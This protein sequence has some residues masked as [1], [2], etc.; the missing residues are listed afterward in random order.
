MLDL[1]KTCL[2]AQPARLLT[3]SLLLISIYSLSFVVLANLIS[4]PVS[5]LSC[6]ASRIITSSRMLVDR[7]VLHAFLW[8]RDPKKKV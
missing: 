1:R 5:P 8:H 4:H 2:G 7:G 3:G 6:P